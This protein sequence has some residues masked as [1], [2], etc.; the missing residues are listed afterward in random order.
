MAKPLDETSLQILRQVRD[1]KRSFTPLDES[2][3]AEEAFQ[4]EARIIRMLESKRYI[5]EIRRINLMTKNGRA[6]INKID[7]TGGLKSK[8]EAAL[9]EEEP[10]ADSSNVQHAYS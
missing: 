3:A 2:V 4:E 8:G 5:R 7:I 1:G 6:V 9:G 10:E